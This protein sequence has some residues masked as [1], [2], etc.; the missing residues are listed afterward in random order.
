MHDFAAENSL[1]QYRDWMKKFPHFIIM[2]ILSAR[3]LSSDI[4]TEL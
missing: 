2:G 4:T 3:A 1:R